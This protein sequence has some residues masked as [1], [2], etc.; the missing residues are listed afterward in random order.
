MSYF[1]RLVDRMLTSGVKNVALARTADQI[2]DIFEIKKNTKPSQQERPAYP[3]TEAAR[4]VIAPKF[5]EIEEQQSP[6]SPST[7]KDKSIPTTKTK[8]K[9][10]V[11][12]DAPKTGLEENV[13]IKE[14][15]TIEEEAGSR[16]LEP[17]S[18]V[19]SSEHIRK[20]MRSSG[21]EST[22]EEPLEREPADN[23][24]KLKVQ[25]ANSAPNQRTMLSES[26]T[27]PCVEQRHETIVGRALMDKENTHEMQ[28]KSTDSRIETRKE[29][30]PNQSHR[31]VARKEIIP[32]QSLSV[33]F[34][35]MVP[36]QHERVQR[37]QDGQWQSNA[38]HETIVTVNIGRIEVRASAH[39]EQVPREHPRFTPP[40]T[41][42][43]YLKQREED[44]R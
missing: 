12:N 41:L 30:I 33:A 42:A 35:V 1:S 14:P 26:S 13:P 5:E 11:E 44:K 10:V 27:M 22:M 6:P 40:L 29:I 17:A 31:D 43:E 18:A 2:P 3:D 4:R 15:P 23:D 37:Q 21:R 39:N 19:K 28:E 36:S 9:A 16:G 8:T 24:D 38:L 7:E 34:P 32:K 20:E 25:A